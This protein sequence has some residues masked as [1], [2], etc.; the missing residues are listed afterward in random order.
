VG[1]ASARKVTDALYDAMEHLRQFLEMGFE[2]PDMELR[3]SGYRGLLEGHYLCVY[4]RIE[5]V[6]FIYQVADTRS[7]YP[8]L[9]K[10]LPKEL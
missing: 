1:P 6:I 7:D 3:S 9:W 4:R 8:Q 5:K 10:T 2:L